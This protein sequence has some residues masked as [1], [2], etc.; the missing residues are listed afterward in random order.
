MKIP[1]EELITILSRFNPWWRRE[2]IPDLPHWRRSVYEELMQ[3]IENP[4]SKRAILLSGARQVG[5][6]TL[7]LQAIQKLIDSGVPSSN[8][9]YVTFDHPVCKLAGLEAVL[10]AWRELEPKKEGPEYLFLDE[11][12]FIQD[13]GTWMKHQVDFFKT[14]CLIFTGSVTPLIEADQ[15]S[16]AGRCP[17]GADERKIYFRR[18]SSFRPM[19]RDGD[20]RTPLVA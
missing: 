5:K 12:Q 1:K 18:S 7:L 14:R 13:I 4:P 6:T 16:G 20:C 9:I 8:I 10:E 17:C 15:E 3:W 11:A 19:C 2:R